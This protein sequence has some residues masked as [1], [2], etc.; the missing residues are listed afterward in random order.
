MWKTDFIYLN[1]FGLEKRWSGT[2]R[3]AFVTIYGET[4]ITTE[5]ERP[6]LLHKERETFITTKGDLYFYKHGHHVCTPTE[7]C[8]AETN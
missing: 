4:C 5:R 3:K 1:G 7:A 2:W 8:F 6:L